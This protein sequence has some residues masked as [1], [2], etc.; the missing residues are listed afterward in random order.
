MVLD[1]RDYTAQVANA[2]LVAPLLWRA[3]QVRYI[4]SAGLPL[5]ALRGAL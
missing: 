2:G 3:G 4:E 1:R 5:G